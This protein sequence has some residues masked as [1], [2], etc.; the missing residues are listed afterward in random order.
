MILPGERGNDEVLHY[1]LLP[2]KSLT[3][4][5]RLHNDQSDTRVTHRSRKHH[6]NTTWPS[7]HHQ[8]RSEDHPGY[9]PRRSSSPRNSAWPDLRSSGGR[10]C[11]FLADEG[12]DL[13]QLSVFYLLWH[14]RGWQEF[15]MS[16]GPIGYTL[17][18]HLQLTP[19]A[20]QVRAVHIELNSLL[21]NFRTVTACF[22]DGSVFTAA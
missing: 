18:V 21:A 7:A 17:R 8:R 3:C 13:I 20:S 10:S 14:R 15:R 12:E 4:L 11:F 5:A 16:L 2:S 19:N 6:C 22:L 9:V 1:P